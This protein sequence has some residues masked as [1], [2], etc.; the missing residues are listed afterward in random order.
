MSDNLSTLQEWYLGSTGYNLE[1]FGTISS[2]EKTPSPTALP[3]NIVALDTM[4]NNSSVAFD[5][6]VVPSFLAH[7]AATHITFSRSNGRGIEGTAV[8]NE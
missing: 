4:A 3:G 6:T 5:C 8:A 2:P 7:N 1:L